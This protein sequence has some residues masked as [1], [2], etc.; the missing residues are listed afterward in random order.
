MIWVRS[1]EGLARR[2]LFVWACRCLSTVTLE[3]IV[4]RLHS[5]MELCRMWQSRKLAYT[6]VLEHNSNIIN[7]I[8]VT[9]VTFLKWWTVLKTTANEI[10]DGQCLIWRV[11]YEGLH[12]PEY[13]TR[14]SQIVWDAGHSSNVE[15]I[16]WNVQSRW[17]L[18][19]VLGGPSTSHGKQR[20]LRG[21]PSGTWR[22][23]HPS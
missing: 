10:L 16:M 3:N 7:C 5:C 1:R 14:L 11:I 23:C 22:L 6:D 2:C 20:S 19:R 13:L 15:C 12:L 9:N 17:R 8:A 21:F 18:P 4:R